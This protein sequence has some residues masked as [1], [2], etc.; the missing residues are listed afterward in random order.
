MYS[1]THELS[2]WFLCDLIQPPELLRVSE[3]ADTYRYLFSGTAKPGKFDSS[4]FPVM[5]EVM[6]MMGH[7]LVSELRIIKSSQDGY[8][9]SLNNYWGRQ[10]HQ[11][12]GSG[13][14]MLPTLGLGERYSKKRIAPMMRETPVLAELIDDKSRNGNNTILEK[15][16]RGGTLTIVG[17]NAPAS[18][19]SDPVRDVV[20]DE[21]DR[22]TESAG[23]EGDPESLIKKRQKTFK[24]TRKLIAGGTPT[25]EGRS[26]TERNY[27]K[28]DQRLYMVECPCCKDHI[29][30]ELEDLQREKDKPH[31]AEFQCPKCRNWIKHHHK[32]EML[33]DFKAGGNAYWKPTALAKGKNR[34]GVYEF[35]LLTDEDRERIYHWDEER[36]QFE[37]IERMIVS[38]ATWSAYSTAVTWQE[39]CDDYNDCKGDPEM[40]QAFYNTMA[41]RAFKYKAHD[42]DSE[43]L[44][45]NA[46][47]DVSEPLPRR[48]RCV[49][50]GV[51]TQNDR[52]ELSE[53]GWAQGEETF[54]LKHSV[55]MG[56]PALVAT[57][58]KLY[59]YLRAISY[60]REDGKKLRCRCAFV[61]SGGARTDSIY[62]F[63]RG[64]SQQRI[65]ACKGLSSYGNPIFTRWSKLKDAQIR[66]ARVGTDTAKENIYAK[67]ARSEHAAPVHASKDLPLSFFEGLIS[68]DRIDTG[69][70]I[71]FT[72]DNKVRNEPLDCAVYALAALRSLPEA[73]A[74]RT[75][76][77]RVEKLYKNL[78][79][80]AADNEEEQE[81]IEEETEE[82]ED[83]RDEA[84]KEETPEP[85]PKRAPRRKGVAPRR[86]SGRTKRRRR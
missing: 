81:A 22:T 40:L 31:Y 14:M 19:S 20:I 41:G 59:N 83:V 3:W 15:I 39:I 60:P 18:L 2:E 77:K 13:M 30:L 24:N 35:D 8:S 10:M 9:E 27:K 65:F 75:V 12:P 16:Y 38:Y 64:K 79:E 58:T 34:S 82:V 80:M 33:K 43:T 6:D 1:D 56:D 46:V 17:A 71:K 78:G 21:E 7:P 50:V 5:R 51:D 84:P 61:D 54:I 66:L 42:L 23:V 62:N 67:L 72:H 69:K 86:S 55:I 32:A 45:K 25:I 28:G 37:P 11:N 47:F 4:V 70:V 29:S 36:G 68:E 48:V 57:R 74:L 44:F 49:T 63:A 85:E 52:F 76:S 53:Y 73:R 26:K